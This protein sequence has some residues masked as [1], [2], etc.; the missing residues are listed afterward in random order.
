[1]V[2]M[3]H[4]SNLLVHS[5]IIFVAQHCL[6]CIARQLRTGTPSSSYEHTIAY[7]EFPTVHAYQRSS[8]TLPW[9]FPLTNQIGQSPL[10]SVQT[11]TEHHET[12][13]SP[14]TS[15]QTASEQ[16]ETIL[17]PVASMQTTSEQPETIFSPVPS[18]SEQHTLSSAQHASCSNKT[19]LSPLRSMQTASE[20]PET[21]LSPLLSMH[22]ASEQLETTLSALPSMQTAPE[23]PETILPSQKKG[24]GLVYTVCTCA[25]C[26][27]TTPYNCSVHESS[28]VRVHTC[29]VRSVR[30]CQQRV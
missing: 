29:L 7:P 10:T 26:F 23:Q 20:Q 11:A 24:E 3:T 4:I 9:S 13:L 27:R 25:K 28:S 22:T 15:M 18:A 12:I 6:M 1:M 5:Y 21:I 30:F 8:S 2:P 16:P 14:L 19:I 17:S